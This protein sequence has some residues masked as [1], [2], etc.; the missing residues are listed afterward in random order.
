MYTLHIENTRGLTSSNLLF[1]YID[2]ISIKPSVPDL[3]IEEINISCQTGGTAKFDLKAG[4][5]NKNKN[6]WLWMSA[7]GTFPGFKLNGLT[8][9]LN[10]D[11]LF[12]FGLFNPGFPGSTGFIGKLDFFG[13]AK[14]QMILP[15]DPQFTMVGFPINFAYVLTEPGPSLPVSYVSTPVHIK[16]IQ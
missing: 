15:A 10:W 16:Y 5:A 13:M 14:A 2:N 3:N 7:T 9:P 4:L 12:E 1:N 8:V 6:Y 11:V